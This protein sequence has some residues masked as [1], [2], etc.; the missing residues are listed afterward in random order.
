MP[1]R[2]P[3]RGCDGSSPVA[4]CCS[5]WRV[6]R[7][8]LGEPEA[9]VQIGVEEAG[10]A[11][12][13]VSGGGEDDD[14]G[15]VRSLLAGPGDVAAERGLPVGTRGHQVKA[16]GSAPRGT[17]TEEGGDRRGAVVLVWCRWHRQ[18]GTVGEQGDDAVDVVAGECFG[19]ALAEVAFLRRGRRRLIVSVAT[20][21][22]ERRS[23]PL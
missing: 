17:G 9:A 14:A 19:E 5:C 3:L 8:C 2:P 11:A 10:Y 4:A 23:R 16:A 18:P 1:T 13:P 12:D 6:N 7:Q 21:P 15:G 20:V 22:V